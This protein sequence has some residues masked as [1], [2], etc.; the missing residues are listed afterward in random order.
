MVTLIAWKLFFG[1]HKEKDNPL[2]DEHGKAVI[3][4]QCS[5]TLYFIFSLLLFLPFS[6]FNFFLTGLVLIFGSITNLYNIKVVL[7]SQTYNYP[8]S[9][10]F[11]K[12]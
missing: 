6:G 12:N 8:L 10:K 4:F 2:Y 1:I 9:I 7:N 5:L 11:L 3:N